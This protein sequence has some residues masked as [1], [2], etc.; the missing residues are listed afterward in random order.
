MQDFQIDPPLVVKDP[1][2]KRRLHSLA[3]ARAFVDQALKLHRPPPWRQ[4]LRRLKSV[5]S[6][7]EALEAIGALRELLEVED[8]L[9]EPVLPQVKPL[10]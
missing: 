5:R 4:M 9:A 1:P 10:R 3:E 8:L 6:E 7:E 2:G